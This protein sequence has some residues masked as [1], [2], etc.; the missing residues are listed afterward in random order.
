VPFHFWLADAYAAAPTPVCILFAGAAVLLLGAV[1]VGVWPGV[2][3]FA[4]RAAARFTD[5]GGYAR[6]VLA[7]AHPPLRGALPVSVPKPLDLGLTAVAGVG[8]LAA[9]A[10]GLGRP[11]LPRVPGLQGAAAAGLAR[12]RDAHS[13]RVGDYVAW[14]TAGTAVLGALTTLTLR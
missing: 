3:E 9:A 7:G 4:T 1:L 2:A 5:P 6:A 14:L 12:L 10:A 11:R 13:G 8:A